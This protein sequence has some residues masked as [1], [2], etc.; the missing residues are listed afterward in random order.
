MGVRSLLGRG[1]AVVVEEVI[2][3]TTVAEV[4]SIQTLVQ[5]ISEE[6]QVLRI[7]EQSLPEPDSTFF[8]LSFCALSNAIGVVS[9]SP[10]STVVT[11]C[12]A[13]S[14][15]HALVGGDTVQVG[16]FGFHR[17]ELNRVSELTAASKKAV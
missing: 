9:E 2:A 3:S 12:E 15:E 8:R 1:A 13:L 16:S 11:L 10:N 17:Y 5:G 6:V 4:Q 7:D 14:P